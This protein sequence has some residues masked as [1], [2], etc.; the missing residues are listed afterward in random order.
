MAIK[1]KQRRDTYRSNVKVRPLRQN[2]L[3]AQN[4]GQDIR[5]INIDHSGLP[6]IGRGGFQN[7]QR[8]TKVQKEYIVDV[9]EETYYPSLIL[10]FTPDFGNWSLPNKGLQTEYHGKEITLHSPS[11]ATGITYRF[12][13]NHSR[14]II[15]TA[16]VPSDGEKLTISSTKLVATLGAPAVITFR[17][18]GGTDT[19]FTGTAA[20][21]DISAMT[22]TQVGT[23]IRVLIASLADYTAYG[24][25]V[26]YI[27][28]YLVS[29]DYD[30]SIT[31][32]VPSDFGIAITNATSYTTGQ[33]IGSSPYYTLVNISD[34]TLEK[35]SLRELW[36]EFI[37][38]A[39]TPTATPPA[40]HGKNTFTFQLGSV[41]VSSAAISFGTIASPLP[42]SGSQET[43]SLR[44][45]LTQ[46]SIGNPIAK[47]VI[48]SGTASL[49]DLYPT[50]YATSATESNFKNIE[51]NREW[52]LNGY[53]ELG[54]T[55]VDALGAASSS[56]RYLDRQ[57]NVLSLYSGY[58]KS[59][60]FYEDIRSDTLLNNRWDTN[61][62]ALHRQ[63]QKFQ[64]N[65]LGLGAG[66]EIINL[67]GVLSSSAGT[68]TAGLDPT[69]ATFSM[70][71]TK[72]SEEVKIRSV[73]LWDK[74]PES[75]RDDHKWSEDVYWM[76]VNERTWTNV[77]N[78]YSLWHSTFIEHIAG[79]H[80]E[81]NPGMIDGVYYPLED[82]PREPLTGKIDVG[83]R[84]SRTVY[85]LLS[86]LSSEQHPFSFYNQ[87]LE[88]T[89][90]KRNINK[91]SYPVQDRFTFP[92]A[93]NDNLGRRFEDGWTQELPGQHDGDNPIMFN[94][95]FDQLPIGAHDYSDSPIFYSS[96]D[97]QMQQVIS[98]EEWDDE[99]VSGLV[100][101]ILQAMVDADG[102][103]EGDNYGSIY[104]QVDNDGTGKK[105]FELFFDKT[106]VWKSIGFDLSSTDGSTKAKAYRATTGSVMTM[107][108]ATQTLYAIFMNSVTGAFHT[109]VQSGV[110]F[111]TSI[112]N[113]TLGAPSGIFKMTATEDN[114]RWDLNS[115]S[116]E[117][118]LSN[119]SV[120]SLSTSSARYP[121][122]NTF[123]ID[124]REW[125]DQQEVITTTGF[126][127]SQS[128]RQAGIVYRELLR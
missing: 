68:G 104:F 4:Q 9:S 7:R 87:F 39:E 107:L 72:L 123:T 82:I 83:L 10:K 57:Q 49:I 97:E 120:V 47:V 23:A 21:I 59:A 51:G 16:A 37:K 50:P 109:Q 88:E 90:D 61:P 73:P 19:Q 79:T 110:I 36:T 103:S 111:P 69:L 85:G 125:Q 17:S 15:Q 6:I 22:N 46:S 48:P 71:E 80:H 28:G 40:G 95:Y 29:T 124:R 116:I 99:R 65:W 128:T 5:E 43:N 53:K 55:R 102:N 91:N 106:K 54:M 20:S 42:S 96:I 60:P 64:T 93:C 122:N 52:A 38:A 105:W 126:I 112:W 78:R 12:V 31:P 44:I 94:N 113:F 2:G 58:L 34:N 118:T 114:P 35:N 45:N 66:N 8:Y 11:Q 1:D 119:N 92:L 14:A 32:D 26:V 3:E 62:R 115:A 86:A 98:D 89:L 127:N 117:G 67:D 63:G 101:S 24:T 56:G 30:L 75:Y 81:S 121:T 27:A 76:D 100:I 108:Q 25:G 41:D 77:Q 33:V 13:T 84:V 74:I 70:G 18:S